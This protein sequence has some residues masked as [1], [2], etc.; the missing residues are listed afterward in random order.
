MAVEEN[1]EERW[2][3]IGEPNGPTITIGAGHD[4][5]NDG[6]NFVDFPVSIVGEGIE[7]KVWVRSSEGAGSG[8]T[9]TEFF[10]ELAKDWKGEKSQPAWEAIEHHLAISVQRDA[11]GHVLLAFDLRQSYRTDAWS[12]R[13]VVKVEPG[14]EMS[15]IAAGLR[16][17]LTVT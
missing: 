16:A 8:T 14:E 6:L 2:L 10:E 4:P 12:V 17:L 7:A 9:L 11:L 5:F 1:L 15:K 13:V 3:R